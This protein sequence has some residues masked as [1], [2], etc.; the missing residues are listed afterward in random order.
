MFLHGEL[1]IA[2]LNCIHRSVR[3]STL[4]RGK[5]LSWIVGS[6][7][8]LLVDIILRIA[9]VLGTL[10]LRVLQLMLDHL[11]LDAIVVPTH[12]DNLLLKVLVLLL[13]HGRNVELLHVVYWWMTLFNPCDALCLIFVRKSL[14]SFGTNHF[15]FALLTLARLLLHHGVS[16]FVAARLLF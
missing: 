2:P 11:L 6:E 14:D 7:A 9:V 12:Q 16:S 3:F 13:I 8:T 4:Y 10:L 15:E 5:L 1:R